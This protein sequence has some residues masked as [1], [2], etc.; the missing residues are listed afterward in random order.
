MADY[1]I[2]YG[3]PPRQT[4]FQKGK[5]GN[6]RGRPKGV[7]N[8]K[9][10]LLEELGE[11]I[12][13]HEQGRSRRLTK[14]RAFVKSVVARAVQ[15]NPGAVAQLVT[16]VLRLLPPDNEVD[17]GEPLLTADEQEILNSALARISPPRQSES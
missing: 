4:R 2:G 14:Q 1:E 16:L 12:S 17:A 15:G 11:R 7:Q 6:P 5:S 8:L 13:V 10:D 3:K 9:T